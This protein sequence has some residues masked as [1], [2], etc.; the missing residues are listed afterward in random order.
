MACELR[1]NGELGSTAPQEGD[2]VSAPGGTLLIMRGNNQIYLL[3]DGMRSD[4]T[5]AD[6]GQ[7]QQ[8]ARLLAALTGNRMTARPVRNDKTAFLLSA[9]NGKR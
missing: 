7:L 2:V 4:V 5:I 8:I 3:V 9:E 6:E 1:C